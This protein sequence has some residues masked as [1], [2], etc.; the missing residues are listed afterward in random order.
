MTNSLSLGA[1]KRH[2][3]LWQRFCHKRGV[4]ASDPTPMTAEEHF[5]LAV[6]NTEVGKMPNGSDFAATMTQ[7]GKRKFPARTGYQ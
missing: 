3:S 1:R 6:G 4:T 5:R 7:D 2:G